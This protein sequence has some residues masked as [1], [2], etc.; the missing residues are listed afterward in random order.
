[1]IKVYSYLE[2]EKLSKMSLK[3]VGALLFVIGFIM[4]NYEFAKRRRIALKLFLMIP[5]DIVGNV[6]VV[7]YMKMTKLL[8]KLGYL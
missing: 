6:H 5:K 2:N 4:W 8:D 7:R 1:M 3:F